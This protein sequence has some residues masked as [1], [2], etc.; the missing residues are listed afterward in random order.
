MSNEINNGLLYTFLGSYLISI[1]GKTILLKLIDETQ[2]RTH[3]EI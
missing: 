2:V 3:G 1:C